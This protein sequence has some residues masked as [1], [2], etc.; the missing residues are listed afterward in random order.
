MCSDAARLHQAGELDKAAAIYQDVVAKFGDSTDA[1]LRELV[2]G[3]IGY[4]A[5]IRLKNPD[6]ASRTEPTPDLVAQLNRTED[7]ALRARLARAIVIETVALTTNERPEEAFVLGEGLVAAV[8]EN[9]SAEVRSNAAMAY[10]NAVEFLRSHG[11][12]P[13]AEEAL[14]DLAARFGN[15]LLAE[16]D[17]SITE[18]GDADRD[19]KLG[20]R[21]RRAELLRAMGRTDEAIEAY[22][23]VISEFGDDLDVQ[24][25]IDRA[26]E[27]RAAL[28]DRRDP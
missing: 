16:Y 13:E 4:R 1:Y 26:R 25:V 15:E 9:D 17:E 18:S 23:G 10:Q 12:R 27:W 21:Y 3:S 6:V 11:R 14:R 28:T 19:T 7:Q 8:D 24:L 22:T 2:V 20:V 5:S